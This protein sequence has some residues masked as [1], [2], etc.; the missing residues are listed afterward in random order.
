MRYRRRARTPATASARSGSSVGGAPEAAPAGRVM[1]G[2]GLT[3]GGG[4]KRRL[5]FSL[6]W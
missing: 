5:D 4:W 3:V 6:V 2:G 1:P